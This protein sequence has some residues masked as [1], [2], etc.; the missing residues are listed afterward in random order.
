MSVINVLHLSDLH[1]G[2]TPGEWIVGKN[3]KRDVCYTEEAE[4]RRKSALDTFVEDLP[5][6]ISDE[7]TPNLIVVSGDIGWKGN[8]DDYKEF[9]EWFSRVCQGLGIGVDKVI[10]CAGN[11]DIKR[12]EV[13]EIARIDLTERQENVIYSLSPKEIAH[14]TSW[15]S[16]FEEC[17]K[18]LKIPRLTNSAENIVDGTIHKEAPH[19]LYGYRQI[20]EYEQLYFAVCNSAWNCRGKDGDQGKLILGKELV[21][22]IYVQNIIEQEGIIVITVL[23]HPFDWLQ[24]PEQRAT[25]PNGLSSV[26][27]KSKIE[28]CSHIILNGHVHGR[29]EESNGD[30]WYSF[31]SGAMYDKDAYLYQC[32]V[33][34]IDTENKWCKQGIVTFN[35]Y[36]F[37]QGDGRYGKW[38]FRKG[39]KKYFFNAN[40]RLLKC[41]EILSIVSEATFKRIEELMEK[42]DDNLE[43]RELLEYLI[44]E[45]IFLFRQV[46]SIALT[47][48][49]REKLDKYQNIVDEIL[50][51]SKDHTK[52]LTRYEEIK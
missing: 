26:T 39:E 12:G 32:E 45:I 19:Y 25:V 42:I 16:D 30:N 50:A 34:Q 5:Q 28:S 8:C 49:Q 41:T 40:Q 10:L 15:F 38:Q 6:I 27:V 18:K 14:K 22:D 21:D 20:E 46:V 29:I 35:Q 43:N 33:I 23:H 7:W 44:S 3:G 13:C 48:E 2:I 11:H 17:L 9:S 36:V 24:N 47:V 51:K 31:T 37:E 1:F 4:K 52:T